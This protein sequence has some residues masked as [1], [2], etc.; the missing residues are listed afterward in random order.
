M[1]EWFS[2]NPVHVTLTSRGRGAL[3]MRCK[4]TNQHMLRRA[5]SDRGRILSYSHFTCSY[6]IKFKRLAGIFSVHENWIADTAA[7]RYSILLMKNSIK[8][9]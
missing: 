7:F 3:C 8:G 9:V 4:N 5:C 2:N 1:Q 6:M